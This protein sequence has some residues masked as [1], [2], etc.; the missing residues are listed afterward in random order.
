MMI[1]HA[2]NRLPVMSGG[3]LVGIVTRADLVR[4]YLRR[5]DDTLRVIRESVLRNTMWIDPDDLRV[6]V[7]DGHVRL[8]GVVDRRSTATIVARLIGLVEGVDHVESRLTWDFDDTGI[9][10]STPDAEP[11]A[12]SLVARERPRSLHG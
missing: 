2:I 4:A 8:E 3:R 7:K 6:E 5:D 1:D 9:A 11:G 12:A 10:P